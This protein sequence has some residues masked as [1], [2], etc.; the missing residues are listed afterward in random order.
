MGDRT[1]VSHRLLENW[2]VEK[3]YERDIV[4]SSGGS[5]LTVS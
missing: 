2:I 5:P 3:N 4:L 1:T